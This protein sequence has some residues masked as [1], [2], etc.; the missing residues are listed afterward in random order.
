VLAPWMSLLGFLELLLWAGVIH[1]AQQEQSK[2]FSLETQIMEWGIFTL[3]PLFTA[4]A[5]LC[6]WF[7]SPE[8]SKQTALFRGLLVLLFPPFRIAWVHPITNQIWL[9]LLGWHRPGKSLSRMLERIFNIPMFLIALLILPV[10]IVEN[11]LPDQLTQRPIL[12]LLLHVG[13]A[14]IWVMFASEFIIKVSASPKTFSYLKERWLDL[15]IVVLPTL[16][17][18]LTHWVDAAPLLRLLRIGR[19]LG[20]Q[21]ISQLS[22]VYRFRGVMMRGWHAFLLL[23]GVSWI[24]GHTPEKRLKRL[25]EQIC[26]LQEQIR[27]LHEEAHELRLQLNQ[28]PIPDQVADSQVK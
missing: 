16:E 8:V 1:R 2:V 25:E 5:V 6:W 22:K 23:K 3:W 21:Q 11:Y 7:R 20:P 19:A 26:E 14:L 13:S 28:Q 10:L 4:E 27:E 24:I 12:A 18:L 9:P 17:F 15:L